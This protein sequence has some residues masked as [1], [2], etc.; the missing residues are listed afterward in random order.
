MK[1]I[2]GVA[3]YSSVWDTDELERAAKKLWAPDI[4]KY[5]DEQLTAKLHYAKGM[6]YLQDWKFPN[7][8][9]ILNGDRQA[10]ASGQAALS[11]RPAAEVLALQ[12]KPT[13]AA[14][15]NGQAFL[16]DLRANIDNDADKRR[17]SLT[18]AQAE[19]Q[20]DIQRLVDK[21]L[22]FGFYQEEHV[23]E[24]GQKF[25]TTSTKKHPMYPKGKLSEI[26]VL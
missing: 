5:T 19:A 7:I 14:R 15:A 6:S 13:N 26:T 3:L 21:H 9:M 2:Y 16:D 4:L 23:D 12:N 8:A 24:T 17:K 1:V 20:A 18:A 25:Y 11:Y 10:G 22:P